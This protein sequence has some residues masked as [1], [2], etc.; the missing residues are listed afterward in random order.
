MIKNYETP[1]TIEIINKGNVTDSFV[2]YKEYENFVITAGGKISFT[3]D[4][5]EKVLYYLNQASKNL[6]VS[7][8]EPM[9]SDIEVG[10]YDRQLDDLIPGAPYICKTLYKTVDPQT[11]IGK[12][13]YEVLG[14]LNYSTDNLGLGQPA[15][16]RFIIKLRNP[17]I[18]SKDQ[19][20]NNPKS[21]IYISD[22]DQQVKTFGKD[23][24][25]EDGSLI[26][27]LNVKKPTSIVTLIVM[28]DASDSET[29]G[30]IDYE[31]TF[32][33]VTFGKEGEVFP[34]LYDAEIGE[35]QVVKLTN[36]SNKTY[37]FIP[38]NDNFAVNIASG[39][40]IEFQTVNAEEVMYYLL[41][42]DNKL[43]VTL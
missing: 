1:L 17:N 34:N 39:D 37:N 6:E 21:I 16:N 13:Y 43:Q 9:D 20:P 42:A 26:V 36:V 11:N 32:N 14:A 22:G 35:H 23:N 38:F 33:N 30:Q 29:H 4:R 3:C 28:W 12:Q 7:F 27:I 41:Q 2:P 15:G 10:S 18:T 24:F 31:F 5:S 8:A 25:Q 40:S 19:I